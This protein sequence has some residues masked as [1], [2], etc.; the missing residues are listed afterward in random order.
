MKHDSG[1]EHPTSW[2]GD[3]RSLHKTTALLARN[4]VE[5]SIPLSCLFFSCLFFNSF[6]LFYFICIA[7]FYLQ[8]PHYLFTR[9]YFPLHDTQSNRTN[10]S[11]SN[12]RTLVN[13][14]VDHWS[15]AM[16]SFWDF[17]VIC[18]PSIIWKTVHSYSF[19]AFYNDLGRIICEYFE[20]KGAE[21]IHLQRSIFLA[22]PSRSVYVIRYLQMIF[23][24]REFLVL[25]RMALI[26]SRGSGERLKRLWTIRQ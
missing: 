10:F 25:R 19:C 23:C 24:Y 17:K 6:W 16:A 5:C 13:Q 26:L 14:L 4:A 18:A 1:I 12:S 7:L 8:L 21:R 11:F 15:C 2:M 20:Q 9:N 3:R 22:Y